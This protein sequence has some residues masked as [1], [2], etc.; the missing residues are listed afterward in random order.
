MQHGGLEE[1]P[2]CCIITLPART[3]RGGMD[4]RW[5]YA[6]LL[7]V[8][9]LTILYS[10]YSILRFNSFESGYDLCIFDQVIRNY[11][12]SSTP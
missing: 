10:Y 1:V 5:H 3:T 6:D 2:L 11:L 4:K 8:L 9:L 7:L 12:L